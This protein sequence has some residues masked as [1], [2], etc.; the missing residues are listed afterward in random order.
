MER[1]SGM[2]PSRASHCSSRV[3]PSRL[4]ANMPVSSTT[5]ITSTK[6]KP[7]MSMPS[8]DC[9]DRKLGTKPSRV[10]ISRPSTQRVMASGTQ[11]SSPV[12]K[13]FLKTR[14]QLGLRSGGRRGRRRGRRRGAVALGGGVGLGRAGRTGLG[15]VGL[16]LAAAVAEVGD[17]PARALE[18]EA[19]G[20][21]LLGEGGFA[22]F[23][24]DRQRR[25]GKLLQYVLGMAAGAAFVSVDRHDREFPGTPAHQKPPFHHPRRADGNQAAPD[26]YGKVLNFS[27]F[28]QKRRSGRQGATGWAPRRVQVP[29]SE[30]A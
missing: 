8:S 7:G 17:I 27:G 11:I 5:R 4:A 18:L 13:Y 6:R 29:D 23:G 9:D 3:R 15:A 1:T 26:Q 21:D 20:R 10:A 19:G 30:D 24:A 2:R 14:I 12:M 28:C 25:I 22:A 16:A